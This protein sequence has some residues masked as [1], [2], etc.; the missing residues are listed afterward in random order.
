MSNLSAPYTSAAA[1]LRR[2]RA[3]V[4]RPPRASARVPGAPGLA[5]A[6]AKGFWERSS[7]NQIRMKRQQLMADAN[8]HPP[9]AHDAS[10]PNTMMILTPDQ[11]AA[12]TG[13]LV[14]AIMDTG[15]NRVAALYRGILTSLSQLSPCTIDI[16]EEM[17]LAGAKTLAAAIRMDRDGLHPGRVDSKYPAWKVGAHANA[18]AHQDDYIDL[19]RAIIAAGLA[20]RPQPSGATS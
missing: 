13:L 15:S 1:R 12:L 10:N 8:R 6:A 20:A 9:I 14:N 11:R 18:N 2:P 3:P 5:P 17:A 16:T 19:S 4:P 7:K